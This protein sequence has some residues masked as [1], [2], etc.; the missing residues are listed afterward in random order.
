VLET[1]QVAAAGYALGAAALWGAGTVLAR[2]VLKQLSYVTLTAIRFLLAI[3]FL[4]VVAA[5]HGSLDESL[6]GLA[7]TP[8]RIAAAALVPGLVA[9]LLFYR[10]L[11]GTQ[12]SHATLAEFMYPAAAL[13][14]NWVVLGVI[15]TLMQ[16]LGLLLVLTTLILLAWLASDKENAA[17][18]PAPAAPRAGANSHGR[19]RVSLGATR[20]A[21][22]PVVQ[23]LAGTRRLWHVRAAA[24]R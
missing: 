20:A 19:P 4:T 14:G 1:D 10:G 17:P 24:K 7:A 23:S 18:F 11:N 8:L 3:P 9:V 13:A 12:A 16:L 15:I 6:T 21:R 22:G 5:G 2:L